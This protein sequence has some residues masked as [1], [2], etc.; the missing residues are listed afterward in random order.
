[1]DKLHGPRCGY[2]RIFTTMYVVCPGISLS[3]KTVLMLTPLD[4]HWIILDNC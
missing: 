1:M 3:F 4:H 2:R